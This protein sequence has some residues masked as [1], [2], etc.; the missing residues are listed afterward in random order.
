[1]RFKG[2][3]VIVSVVGLTTML[4]CTGTKKPASDQKPPE[5]SFG[6]QK[7]PGEPPSQPKAE[8]VPKRP[9]PAMPAEEK[10]IED[11]KSGKADKPAADT[12]ELPGAAAPAAATPAA[13]EGAP[14]AGTINDLRAALAAASDED[15]RV[16]A[17]DAIADLGQ[18]ALPALD[19]LV[20]AMGD[21]NIRLRWHAARAIG[22]IGEDAFPVLPKLVALLKDADPIVVTQA[23]TAIR[24]IRADEGPALAD[25]HAKAYAEAVDALA[26][27]L[28]HAD[29]RVRRG[30]LKA[31]AALRPEAGKLADLLDDTLSDAD[32][33]VVMP[34]LES[35][36]DLGGDAVPVLVEA[37]K[38]PKSRYW[39]TV[40]LT[41]IGPAAAP[42]AGALTAAALTGEPEERM[43][44]MLA[45][46]AIGEPAAEAADELSA[47]LDSPDTA[48]KSSA[49]YALGRMR[50]AS[51]DAALEKASAD[52]DPFLAGIASWARAR[53]HPEDKTLVS[54][55]LAT[56][57]TALGSDRVNTR[58]AAMSA[59]SD[60][61]G[62][63]DDADEATLADRFVGLLEDDHPAV[64][65]AA[66]TS[67]VRLGPTAIAALE[68]ALDKPALRTLAM[69]LLAAAGSK[70][71]PAVDNLVA[72][73]A[74]ADPATR[75]DAAVALAA[76]GPEAAEA[77]PALAKLLASDEKEDA[78]RYAAAY[79]LGRIGPA[80]ASVAETLRGLSKSEDELMASVAIW[81]L[82]K[83]EPENKAQVAAA[84]PALRK[85]LR[86]KRDLARLEAAAALGDLGAAAVSAVPM[87]E[88]VSEDDPL[89]AVRRAA[90]AAV[91]KIKAAGN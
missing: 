25:D 91:A 89:P 76:I 36:A 44:A 37:L 58:I 72:A 40:A 68:K 88:L 6:E 67:L 86:G 29:P 65:G 48:V 51:A 32:P 84:V 46:A 16:Q 71:K 10:S 56:L 87:L 19:D 57:S 70:A 69:E 38:H 11:E 1:M 62:S 12:L 14:G 63:L 20:K 21:E 24:E 59:L 78:L 41:E 23:A 15:G 77:V 55:A 33:S 90:A 31:I 74:D 34:A 18:N 26:A 7:T 50:V 5:V 45:L 27:T 66:A 83:I 49:A 42:A 39:A 52:G 2:T 54:A 30:S 85:A 47:A 60:L 17:V 43:Q 75:G 13:D 73:L 8:G 35:L 64:R 81:A 3:I 79:A 22:R 61:T 53:I 9:A 28:V 80:S 82:L 4:G